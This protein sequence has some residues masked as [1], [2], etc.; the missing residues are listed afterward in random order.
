VKKRFVE[1]KPV[2]PPAGR[3]KSVEICP[4]ANGFKKV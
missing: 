3:A 2:G 1:V 4:V